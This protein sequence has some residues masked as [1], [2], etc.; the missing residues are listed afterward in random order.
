MT[1]YDWRG[2]TERLGMM[3]PY[4]WVNTTYDLDFGTLTPMVTW[5]K[6]ARDGAKTAYFLISGPTL[7]RY[8]LVFQS[9]AIN[10]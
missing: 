1:G 8:D 2:T 10:G 6:T 7:V 5:A 3:E 4:L 9:F